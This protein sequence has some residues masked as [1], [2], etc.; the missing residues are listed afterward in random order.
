MSVFRCEEVGE[1]REVGTGVW[2]VVEVMSGVGR[3]SLEA[4]GTRPRVIVIVS[5]A[6]PET[7]GDVHLKYK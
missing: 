2:R 6:S 1:V 4:A 3:G 7:R 5:A